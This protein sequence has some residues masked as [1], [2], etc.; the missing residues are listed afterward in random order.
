MRSAIWLAASAH[1]AAIACRSSGLTGALHGSAAAKLL[2]P[3][4]AGGKAAAN[5]GEP[6]RNSIARVL[7]GSDTCEG[8]FPA[9]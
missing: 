5:A 1:R 4:S 7:G 3:G 8:R 6:W 9:A 2:L